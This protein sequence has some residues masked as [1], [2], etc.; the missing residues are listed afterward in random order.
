MSFNTGILFKAPELYSRFA[1]LQ[2]EYYALLNTAG[3]EYLERLEAELDTLIQE[4]RVLGSKLVEID[5]RKFAAFSDYHVNQ[6]KLKAAQGELNGY[7]YDLKYNTRLLTRTEQQQS[8]RRQAEL[9]ADIE[10]ITAGRKP[11]VQCLQHAGN[12]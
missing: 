6:G 1:D 10:T 9:V 2:G 4:E 12:Q 3:A 5:N 7:S 8:Q 11:R